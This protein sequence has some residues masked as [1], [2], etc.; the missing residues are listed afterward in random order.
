MLVLLCCSCLQLDPPP[1]ISIPE[2]ML[3]VLAKEEVIEEFGW[4]MIMR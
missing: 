2:E 1:G 4:D 3:H